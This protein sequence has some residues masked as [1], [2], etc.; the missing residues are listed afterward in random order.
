MRIFLL[1]ILALGMS[2]AWAYSDGK[3]QRMIERKRPSV[4]RGR[5]SDMPHDAAK[6]MSLPGDGNV[7]RYVWRS[8]VRNT[9]GFA[10]WWRIREEKPRGRFVCRKF[11]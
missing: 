1:V 8:G 3:D 2:N 5:A 6:R 10:A 11:L 4:W 9:P 7:G